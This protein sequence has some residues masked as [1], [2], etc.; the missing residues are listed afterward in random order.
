[1]N[2]KGFVN[3]LVIIGIII[4]AGIAGYVVVNR[5]TQKPPIPVSERILPSEAPIGAEISIVGSGFTSTK[6]SLQF[7]IGFAYLN[8]LISSDGET[9]K[10]T[11]PESFDTCNPDGSVCAEL[12]S[13][14]IPGQIYEV[15]VINANGRSN[16]VN[17]TVAREEVAP[18]PTPT[19]TPKPSPSPASK[20]D[21][22]QILLRAGQRES[23]FLLE[24]IYPD[25]VTGLNFWEYPVATG[26]G[27][28]VTLR[29][30]E[31]VSNGC[32]VTLTLVSIEGNTA[33]FIKK[34][35]FNRP[36]PICLAGNTLIE[37]PSGL[38]SVKYLQIG[39][40]IWTTDTSGQRVSGV[41]QKTSKV[42]VPL[43]HQMIH[44]V[45][46]DGRELFA[47]PGHPIIDG[48][49][50]GDLVANDFYDDARVVAVDRV[51]YDDTATYDI[52]PSGETGFYWANGILLG[53]TLR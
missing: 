50:V 8:N 38:V 52:L 37:T 19:P 31:I 33:T 1:M 4:L 30:G 9:I 35:D 46:D 42:P 2:Q 20:P 10:F 23:S 7:G 53:S 24:K 28:P 39:M 5:Q 16:Y 6:N 27:Q 45:L 49:I 18:A 51:T 17:F 15:G 44:L 14:P 40:S 34:T 21:E 22:V 36:C 3:I 47:S 12:L 48:R 25:R 11:L 13:R 26:Q 32:T 43:T 29:I 41:V